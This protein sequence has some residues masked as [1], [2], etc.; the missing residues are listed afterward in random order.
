MRTRDKILSF[1]AALLL[2]PTSARADTIFLT[3]GSMIGDCTVVTEGLLSVQYKTNKK[4]QE[5]GSD[6]VLM[7]EFDRSPQLVDRAEAAL[8][9]DQHL[10]AVDDFE[11]YIS[12]VIGKSP[13][14]YKWAPAYAMYRV[15]EINETMGK[16]GAVVRA[17]DRLLA[18][19][20]D[21]RYVPMAFLKKA[22]ALNQERKGPAVA[23]TLDQLGKIVESKGLSKRWQ[24]ELD[25]ARLVYT[26]SLRGAKLRARLEDVATQASAEFP[27]V[28]NRADVAI[29]ESFFAEKKL[30]EAAEIFE[31][32]TRDP[33]ADDRT[34]AAAY[35]GNGDCLFSK[36]VAMAS[37]G[38]DPTA[39]F[40]AAL[41]SYMRVVV[42]YKQELRYVPK[43]MFYAG[44][45]YQ[46]SAD[47]ESQDRAQKLYV[48]VLRNF[49]GTKWA[50]EA[51]GFRK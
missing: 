49:K 36:G 47:Q 26:A 8:A 23:K 21:S 13:S 42:V 41:L 38:E 39:V 11:D 1:S 20:P 40:K 44:R 5:V 31:R 51:R 45:V 9:D 3:D 29:A 46:Q 2:V 30:D 12:G 34:L 25:L 7:I 6:K 28:R 48:G 16:F 4:Q 43:A 37:A 32:I 24:L 10:T 15:V 27:T 19:E 14:R 17:A 35:T 18:Q 33:Q 50:N 22:D